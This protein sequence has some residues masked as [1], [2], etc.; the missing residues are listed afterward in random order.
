LKD[1]DG[2]LFEQRQ[3][4][5]CRNLFEPARKGFYMQKSDFDGYFAL[6]EKGA[7]REAYALLQDIIKSQPQWSKVGDL[8]VWCADLE[9]TLNDD[10]RKAGELLDKAIELGC[11]NTAPYYRVRGY[12]LWRNGD[13]E[14]GLR[15]LEK[16]VELDPSVTNLATFGTLLSSDHDK[17]ALWVW[18]RVLQ[19]DPDNCLAHIYLGIDA[20]AAGDRAKA[21]LMAKRAEKLSRSERDVSE[22]GRLY[23]ELGEFQNALD[24]YLKAERLGGEPK[25]VLYASI[26]TCY[27]AL[28]DERTGRKFADWALRCNPENDY[29]KKIWQQC[30]ERSNQCNENS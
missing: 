29:V 21:L 23:K 30:Q 22:I 12:V 26:A 15:H 14:V 24:T 13:H 18:Q 5:S 25:G 3:F 10:L 2:E 1:R 17:R 7:Y 8:Y 27:F 9:L 19:K 16:S 11:A 28:G 20:A 6:H 4:F